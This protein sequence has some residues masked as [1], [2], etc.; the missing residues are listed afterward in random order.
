MA[1]QPKVSLSREERKRNTSCAKWQV[2]SE[3]GRSRV[4]CFNFGHQFFVA[5]N[6]N[7]GL[8]QL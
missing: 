3:L 1:T 2:K 5:C 6:Q 7:R 8:K 4:K